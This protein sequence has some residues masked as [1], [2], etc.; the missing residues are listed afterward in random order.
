MLVRLITILIGV[1]F[2]FCFT[3]EKMGETTRLYDLTLDQAET[4]ALEQNNQVNALRELYKKAKEG[5]LESYSKWMP[6]ITAM[7]DMY[8]ASEKQ[9]FT[10]AKSAFLTQ[11]SLTQSIIEM[12]SYY[13]VKIAKLVEEQLK[14]LLNAAI[15]DTLFEV[16]SLYYQV[17]LD[18]ETIEA[19]KEKIELLVSL[20]KKMEERYEIGT[21]ILYNVN[22]S[23]VAIAN[24]TTEY[25]EAIKK[26]KIDRDLL[27]S[28]L[29]F[30]PGS[31]EISFVNL[32]IPVEDIPILKE[33]LH[34]LKAIFEDNE[35]D[36]NRKIYT[37]NYPQSELRKTKQLF[38]KSEMTFWENKA[39]KLQPNLKVY[40]NELAIAKKETAKKLGEY[41]PKLSLNINYGGNPTDQIFVPATRFNNQKF[42]WGVGLQFR[43]MLFDSLGR[44][45][46][47]KQ[48][49]YQAKSKEFEYKKG[50]QKTYTN[51]RRQIYSIE[52]SVANFVTAEANVKL[53]TQTVGLAS[54]Q[55]EIGYAT[56]FDYQIT[57]NSLIQALN[58]K[59]KA[60]YDLI[61]AYFGLRHACGVDLEEE[62]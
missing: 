49:R 30:D 56:I 16:R 10:N 19:A 44:E 22:Q 50:L 31:V 57:V 14:L 38:S 17:I 1:Y 24:A 58:N 53:A 28:A 42:E 18:Y 9:V 48:A 27:V 7:S 60:R 34:Q 46:R 8:A 62:M 13:N 43:W 45:R 15:I 5:K 12:D 40:A 37:D 26:Q 33:K 55:L 54:D 36:L 39:L 35:L 52:E 21:S 20:S 47:V 6:K 11:L 61:N 51:V 25:Y 3:E 23:K 59:N 2:S 29:G 41:A 32:R 4:I